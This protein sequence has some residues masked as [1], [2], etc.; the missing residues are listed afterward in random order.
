MTVINAHL[1]VEVGRFMAHQQA[2]N[3]LNNK[4]KFLSAL[5]VIALSVA[6]LDLGIA[7]LVHR[8]LLG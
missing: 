7:D 3:I 4:A 8:I 5:T 1:S 2:D 6:L